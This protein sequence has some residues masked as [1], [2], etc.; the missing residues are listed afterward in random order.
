M[1]VSIA[2]GK[3][4]TGKT[5]V[6]V[7]LALSL[8]NVQL[9]DCD[10]EEPNIHIFLKPDIYKREKVTAKIPL[11]DEDI[12]DRCGKCAEFCQY[13]ALAVTK[14]LIVILNELC[15]SCGGCVIVCPKKAIS[16]KEREIGI[17]EYGKKNDIEFIHGILN[18]GEAMA[19][20]LIKRVK[21][22]VKD[23]MNVIIDA[24][25]G[26]SCAVIESVRDTE[27]CILVT[28]PTP[29][30]LND[31][32]LAVEMLN[33]IGISYGVII[34]RD[35]IGDNKVYEYCNLNR[36]PILMKIPYNEEIAKLYSDGIPFVDIMN[37]YKERFRQMFD[38]ISR[39]INK[40]VNA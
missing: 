2:S 22:E 15:H 39:E 19:S 8:C 37:E 1:I 13:N 7:N 34:N 10:V 12:C 32:K 24:P 9:L 23:N 36:I 11:I 38:K 30:G 16:E 26:T 18:T 17:L 20:P 21:E 31:L 14:D 5:T 28:E 4:G 33:E 6:A 27:Y 3:G 25:P 40:E 29:F 35:G